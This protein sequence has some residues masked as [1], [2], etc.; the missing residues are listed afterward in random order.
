MHIQQSFPTRE[1]SQQRAFYFILPHT[2]L[3]KGLFGGDTSLKLYQ[4][5]LLSGYFVEIMNLH[6]QHTSIE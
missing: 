2:K 6:L 1:L 5:T 3:C 4:S